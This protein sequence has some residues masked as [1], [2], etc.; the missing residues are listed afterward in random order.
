M[1]D[2]RVRFR[3]VLEPYWSPIGALAPREAEQE[4]RVTTLRSTVVDIEGDNTLQALN[5]S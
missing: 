5:S 2:T 4:C 3:R 1:E